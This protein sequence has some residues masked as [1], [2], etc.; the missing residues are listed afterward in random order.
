MKYGDDFLDGLEPEYLREAVEWA[1]SLVWRED[2]GALI[3]DHVHC[4]ICTR[5]VKKGEL[6]C[7]YRSTAKY[8]C[9][10]CY[11]QFIAES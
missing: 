7:V 9:H 4:D 11:D 8:M 2:D 1:K 3:D 10:I 5:P 6:G